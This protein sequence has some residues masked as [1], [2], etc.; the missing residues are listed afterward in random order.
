MCRKLYPKEGY[1]GSTLISGGLVGARNDIVD[2]RSSVAD[3][4]LCGWGCKTKAVA[5][6]KIDIIYR[7]RSFQRMKSILFVGDVYTSDAHPK[8]S[9]DAD[10]R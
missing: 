5:V 2:T 4:V 6:P 1:L 7:R 8:P 9:I 3:I 10:G